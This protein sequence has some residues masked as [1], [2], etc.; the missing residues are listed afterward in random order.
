MGDVRFWS[1]FLR[2]EC[3]NHI[4]QRKSVPHSCDRNLPSGPPSLGTRSG[5]PEKSV[6]LRSDL[7]LN[8][9]AVKLNGLVVKLNMLCRELNVL[10]V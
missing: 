10:D 1:K 4:N 2:Q 7:R 3:E 9:R 8:I 6:K 5:S